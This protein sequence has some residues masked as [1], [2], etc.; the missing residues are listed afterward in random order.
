MTITKIQRS[1]DP[2]DNLWHLSGN[3]S[4]ISAITTALMLSYVGGNPAKMNVLTALLYISTPE[5]FKDAIISAMPN[6][7]EGMAI[8]QK[9]LIDIHKT[10]MTK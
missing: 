8:I 2:K 10:Q 1:D 3:N 9:I 5:Q 4:E 6:P 7:G